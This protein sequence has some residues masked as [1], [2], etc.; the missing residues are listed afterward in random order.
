MESDA[1]DGQVFWD[2]DAGLVESVE[3]SLGNGVG[4]TED[5]IRTFT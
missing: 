4:V 1:Y 5:N 3:C 2:T